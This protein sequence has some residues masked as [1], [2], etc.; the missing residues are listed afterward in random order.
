MMAYAEEK[1]RIVLELTNNYVVT[2]YTKENAYAQVAI[3][4]TYMY[5]SAEVVNHCWYGRYGYG[6]Y[7]CYGDNYGGLERLNRQ[8]LLGVILNSDTAQA[9]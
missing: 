5:K 3:S 4:T 8:Q 7:G 2:E 1:E 9:I 6:Y